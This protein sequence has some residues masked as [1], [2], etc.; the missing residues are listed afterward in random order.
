M[1]DATWRAGA[2]AVVR[3]T[4]ADGEP[5]RTKQI[6]RR[7]TV[8]ARAGNCYHEDVGHATATGRDREEALGAAKAAAV[9]DGKRRGRG[10]ASS[11]PS[12]RGLAWRSSPVPFAGGRCAA[13]ATSRRRRPPLRRRRARPRRRP[14]PR[15][16]RRRRGPRR[17]RRRRR[18]RR[19]RR[20][21]GGGRNL[22]AWWRPRRRAA[23]RAWGRRRGRA[24]PGARC[25]GAA[26]SRRRRS[27]SRAAGARDRPVA[28]ARRARRRARGRPRPPRR[29]HAPARRRRRPRARRR[30]ARRGRP[31][32]ASRDRRRVVAAA[33]A[34][35][36]AAAA[37]GAA[38]AASSSGPSSRG[39]RACRWSG[40]TCRR[41]RPRWPTTRP[42]RHPVAEARARRVGFQGPLPPRPQGSH[43]LSRCLPKPHAKPAKPANDPTQC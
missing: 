18:G 37:A 10:V 33:A 15:P 1:S 43:L 26:A 13:S 16:R 30:A 19:G 5:Q 25:A 20:A 2:T 22:A 31:R 23:R 27:A 14:R 38:A 39:P 29:R 24:H 11:T 3:V 40:T 21:R 8:G 34:R 17:R 9:K 41:P 4:L 32:P 7:F 42:G 36:R 28:P 12:S 6:S 35:R